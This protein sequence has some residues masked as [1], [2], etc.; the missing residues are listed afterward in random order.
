[1]AILEVKGVSKRFGARQELFTRI[2]L[3]THDRSINTLVEI[4]LNRLGQIDSRFLLVV[5]RVLCYR[6]SG[7][8]QMLCQGQYPL[9]KLPKQ[10]ARKPY[11]KNAATFHLPYR[12]L[13]I[14]VSVLVSLSYNYVSAVSSQSIV[15]N[16]SE[17]NSYSTGTSTLCRKIEKSGIPS[18]PPPPREEAQAPTSSG[19]PTEKSGR[20]D[21]DQ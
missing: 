7:L 8:W 21:E 4:A 3:W 16:I 1:M 10:F 11:Q 19:P 15:S 6:P 2:S 5:K 9:E 17:G 20:I 18:H 13:L 14:A 12:D